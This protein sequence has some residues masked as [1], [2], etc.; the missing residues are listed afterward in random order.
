[1]DWP[2]YLKAIALG[3]VVLTP[4]AKKVE[5]GYASGGVSAPIVAI[6]RQILTIAKFDIVVLFTVI[7]DMVLK[8]GYSDWGILLA[9]VIVIVAAGYVWL[10]PVLRAAPVHT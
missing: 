8:P 6:C 4:R 3:I 10:T 5:A 9:M 7:A 2:L 1:M